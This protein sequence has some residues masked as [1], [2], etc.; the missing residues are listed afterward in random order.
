MLKTIFAAALTS[1]FTVGAYAVPVTINNGGAGG[2]TATIDDAGNFDITGTPGLSY[3]G[4]EYVNIDTHSA[5]Y[6]FKADANDYI[7]YGTNPFGGTT[8][9]VGGSAAT[10]LSMGGWSFTQVV[11]ASAPNRITVSLTLT[12]H[13]GADVRDA[14]WSTG[15]DPDQDGSGNNTTAN[16]ITGGPGN[17]AAVSATGPLSNY[18]VEMKNTTSAGAFAIVAFIN[19]GDCCSPVDPLVAFGGPNA[20]GTATLADDSISL[21]YHFGA[22]A[23]GSS[24][25]IGY[26][27]VFAVPEPETYALMLAGLAVVGWMSRRRRL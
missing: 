20:A 11:S 4:R 13:T 8:Y 2:V 17:T 6:W 21:A 26:E 14:Y 7:A 5:W 9:A 1:A 23:D 25:S 16:L 12:N 15:F 24:V 3:A 22:I 10:T 18:S 19:S 27:Y